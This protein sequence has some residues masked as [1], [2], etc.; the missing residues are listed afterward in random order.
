MD[1]K[2]IAVVPARGGSKGVKLK[3]LRK[4]RGVSLIGY[5]AGV[6]QTLPEIHTS[7]ISSDHADIISEAERFGLEAPFT[8]PNRLSGDRISDIE[9]LTHALLKMEMLKG[10][11][12]DI[13]LMLQPT[14]P[15]RTAGDVRKTLSK[16]VEGGYDSVFTVSETDSKGHP[17]KQFNLNGNDISY[18]EDAGA[19]IIARQEL[20]PVFHKNG[21]A[22]ALTRKCLLEQK[23][24]LG[25]RASFVKTE[26]PVINIDSEF[27]L[28]LANFLMSQEQSK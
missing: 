22:Y 26:R 20:K 6:I 27:D 24:L 7:I 14:S 5:V 1:R 13:I 12:Y 17:L 3:N 10:Y 15:F 19:A 2:I 25:K 9:V 11:E 28:A 23:T 16:L 18:Y 8:R 4:I 21:L